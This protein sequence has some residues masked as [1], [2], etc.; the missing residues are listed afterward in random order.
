MNVFSTS[1]RYSQ[2]YKHKIKINDGHYR[3][4]N[5]R[6]RITSKQNYA[7]HNTVRIRA[8]SLFRQLSKSRGTCLLAEISLSR[9]HS[10]QVPYSLP[11]ASTSGSKPG[12][13]PPNKRF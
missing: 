8:S 5:L 10:F 6:H 7:L 11:V 13:F 12:S 2:V 4:S 3:T 1:Q 9:T